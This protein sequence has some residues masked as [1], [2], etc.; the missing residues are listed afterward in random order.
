MSVHGRNTN[1]AH[2]TQIYNINTSTKEIGT[3]NK[4][5]KRRKKSKRSKNS[6]LRNKLPENVK[7]MSPSQMHALKGDDGM[8]LKS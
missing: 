7:S 8:I 1:I 6:K 5:V 4:S 2:A 3:F